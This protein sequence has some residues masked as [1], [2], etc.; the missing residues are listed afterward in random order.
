MQFDQ[1]RV[2]PFAAHQS[3]HDVVHRT[4]NYH[5]EKC[6]K[7]EMR[8]SDA[9]LCEVDVA[10]DRAQRNQHANYAK[11]RVRH[12]TEHGE[13]QRRAVAHQRKITLHGHVVVQADGSDGNHRQDGRGDAGGDH[14]R[15][16]RPIDEPLHS[17]PARE[18]RVGPKTDCR[19]MITVHRAADYLGNHVVRRAEGNGAEP[20][21]E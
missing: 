19:Q 13:P 6:V 16:K 12:R 2:T 17:G 18:K 8:V 11:D 7:T 15:R 1:R 9:G 14:P 20:Q 4:E 3:R 21:K 5:G 10:R